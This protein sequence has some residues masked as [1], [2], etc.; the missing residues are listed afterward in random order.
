MARRGGAKPWQ[1]ESQNVTVGHCLVSPLR[2]LV[3]PGGEHR[4]RRNL[5]LAS[6]VLG[7][8]TRWTAPGRSKHLQIPLAVHAKHAQINGRECQLTGYLT[9]SAFACSHSRSAGSQ[10]WSIKS[11]NR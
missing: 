2:L 11:R 10:P 6:P 5:A 3:P 9:Q 4:W 1:K 8:R 7:R